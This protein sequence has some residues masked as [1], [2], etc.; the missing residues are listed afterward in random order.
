MKKDD[1]GVWEITLPAGTIKH[2]TASRSR[3]ESPIKG[4]STFPAWITYATQEPQLGAHYDG[5]YWDPPAGEKYV[6][7]NPRPP[8]PAA[9]RGYEASRIA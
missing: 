6:R 9:S 7:Q 4:G 3:C 1:F 5:V 2:G 8:R